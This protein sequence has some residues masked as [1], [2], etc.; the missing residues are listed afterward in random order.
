MEQDRCGSEGSVM[1]AATTGS[2]T[3]ADVRFDAAHGHRARSEKCHE[4]TFAE[5]S[6]LSFAKVGRAE[7]GP[8]RTR[9]HNRC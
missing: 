6:H 8:S 9:K 5:T 7:Q 1:N 4:E 2:A 3:S